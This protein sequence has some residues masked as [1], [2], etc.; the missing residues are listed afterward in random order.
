VKLFL[1]IVFLVILVIL[2]IKV[3]FYT[4][5]PIGSIP[6]GVTLLVWRAGGEPTFNSP[7]AV[8]LKIQDGVSLLCRGMALAQAP[9]DRIIVRLPYMHWAYL[10]STGGLAFDR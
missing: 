10:R 6:E 3:G 5:Q 4:V 9:I 8:C 1:G 7:D 2:F